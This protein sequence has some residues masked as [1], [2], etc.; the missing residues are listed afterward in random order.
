MSPFDSPSGSKQKVSSLAAVGNGAKKPLLSSVNKNAGKS[1]QQ[2][3]GE[4]LIPSQMSSFNTP[5]AENDKA[6]DGD[7]LQPS[8]FREGQCLADFDIGQC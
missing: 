2:N 3:G 4:M 7:L 1:S 6:R 8:E 5:N